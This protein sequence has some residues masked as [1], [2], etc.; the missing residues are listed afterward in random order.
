MVRKNDALEYHRA[1]RPG[2]LEVVP[3]KPLVTQR[4]LSLAYSP[5]VAEPCLEIARDPELAWEYTARGNLV[6]VVTNGTA[7]LGLGNIGPLAGK[8][9][10]EGKACLF[11]KFADIDV[12]DLE[13]TARDSAA[14][15][16]TVASLEPTF[17]G[18][19]LEDLKAPECFEIEAGLRARMGIPVFHDDQHGTAIISGAALMNGAEL[20]GKK[21][22]ALKIVVSGAGA[23]AIAC[24]EFYVS[25]GVPVENITL[26]D[27]LGV[28]YAG[29]EQGM[30]PYKARF[31]R[32]D[33]GARTRADAVRGAD[34]FLGLSKAGLCTPEMVRDMAPRPLIF[35]LANPDPEISYPDAKGARPD[36]IVATGRSDYPNQVNN[37]LGFPFVFRGAL[38]VRAR[39]INE[40]M[41]IAA[42][43]ALA[44]L[45][46]EP[47]P[48]SVA[49]AYG[50]R[51]FR[52]GPEYIIPKPFDT[53]VLWWCAPAVAGAAIESGAARLRLDLDEYREQLRRRIGGVEQTLMRRIVHRAKSAP[54]RVVFPEG[55]N[56]KVLR[57]CQ[58]VLDEGIA[59]PILLGHERKIRQRA[60]ELDLDLEGVEII[61]PPDAPQIQAYGRELFDLRCR[62]GV[63]AL[64]AA[65]LI[66]RRIY[67]GMMMVRHGDAAGLVAGL[68][69][70]YP[71][72]IRPALQVLGIRREVRRATGMYMMLLKNDVKF[73][74]DATVNIDPDAETLADIAIQVADAVRA[75]EITPRIAMISF[76]NFGSAPHPESQ[77]VAAAVEIVRRL[78]PDLEIDG[79]V[80]ADIAVDAEKLHEL[81]P[82]TRL[83]E[84]ANV[85]V[86]PSLAAGNAAY[87]VL[88]ALGGATAIGPILLGVQKP[89]AVLPRDANVDTIVNMTAYTVARS[90]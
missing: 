32:K 47:V 57:A 38:D 37:V 86:F 51:A 41:K 56:I 36:A 12:Y 13:I 59:R 31:A 35:A 23:S 46:H 52:F 9:V 79:E 2:K 76:S 11:K 1:G 3:T 45:A 73:F 22:G 6:A 49:E 18:I 88:A 85:L 66:T 39:E 10:M 27:S 34:V 68:T 69:A 80:Q 33:D 29:R 74:A 64:S 63:T 30:N 61:H 48:D 60:T 4:D 19:N 54:R 53:R 8:P 87:K 21:L 24:A 17:G 62:K 16:D 14:F 28:I 77:R 67:F 44:A 81:F 25:L 42:A 78:R 71:D 26:V 75:F 7:V 55:D 89:V 43:R 83:T 72:T 58:I 84:A 20:A 90:G 65:R 82:F 5:G 40:Q 70:P 15:I 50:V